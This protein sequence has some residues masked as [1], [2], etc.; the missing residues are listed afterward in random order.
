[1]RFSTLWICGLALLLAALPTRAEAETKEFWANFAGTSA[2]NVG[3][4][5]APFNPAPPFQPGAG[6]GFPAFVSH[7]QASGNLGKM[8]IDDVFETSPGL[9]TPDCLG[10][11]G[12]ADFATGTGYASATASFRNGRDQ[13]EF[14]I[15]TRFICFD[16]A[17]GFTVEDTGF[18]LG[19]SGKYSNV[20]G[21]TWTG[22]AEGRV[23]AFN[24][25]FFPLAT[26][27]TGRI[28]GQLQLAD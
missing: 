26:I 17:G 2:I 15:L 13:I 22:R 21:G 24:Q 10:G 4:D 14:Q 18:I 19:G 23:R 3:I 16:D 12:T 9:M 25:L 11:T 6:D 8:V 27:F 7:S 1:M 20:T 5:S 28:E